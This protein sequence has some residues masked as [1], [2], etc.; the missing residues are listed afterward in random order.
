MKTQA[1]TLKNLVSQ[2]KLA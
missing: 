1:Q 2:F